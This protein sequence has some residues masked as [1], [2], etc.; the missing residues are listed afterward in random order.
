MLLYNELTDLP[1]SIKA[2]IFGQMITSGELTP[3]HLKILLS[4]NQKRLDLSANPGTDPIRYL[5]SQITEK[6]LTFR[7]K[8]LLMEGMS[9]PLRTDALSSNTW[10]SMTAE[11]SRMSTDHATVHNR[12]GGS[13]FIHIC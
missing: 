13:F 3:D 12:I 2:P 7:F 10:I 11:A 6:C 1:S 9:T 5:D 4:R 8:I